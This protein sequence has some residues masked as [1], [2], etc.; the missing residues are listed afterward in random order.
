MVERVDGI[1]QECWTQ[2]KDLA[3][4]LFHFFAV[5]WEDRGIGWDVPVKDS[6][7]AVAAHIAAGRE[8]RTWRQSRH[9]ISAAQA[10][11]GELWARL[12]ILRDVGILPE[13]DFLD[14]NDRLTRLRLLIKKMKV[15]RSWSRF[16]GYV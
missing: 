11:A 6:A 2:A 7:V 10:A 9:S 4:S 13:G 15:E 1:S 12:I 8:G 14:L 3:V 5:G 16:S